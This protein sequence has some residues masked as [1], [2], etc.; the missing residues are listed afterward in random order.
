MKKSLFAS[1]LLALFSSQV[2]AN[3]NLTELEEELDIM[4]NILRTSLQQDKQKAGLRVGQM[5][6]TYLDGQGVVFDM[7]TSGGQHWP[8]VLSEK[9]RTLFI[10]PLE[11]LSVAFGEDFSFH[12]DSDDFNDVVEQAQEAAERARDKIHRLRDRQRDYSWEIRELERE[13]RDLQFAKRN[14]DKEQAAEITAELNAA[15]KRLQELQRQQNQMEQD[16]EQLQA[17][18]RKLAEEQK[19]AQRKLQGRFLSDFEAAL[20]KTLCRYGSGL[21]ALPA[22]EKIS[23]VLKRF[24]T[25]KDGK[26]RKDRIY[27]FDNSNVQACVRDK[28]TQEQLLAKTKVYSF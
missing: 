5:N 17:E 8:L 18:Q 24:T 19:Q 1:V 20:G 4:R 21:R 26:T 23:F 6:Y 11:N 14:A 22:Q 28:L 12:F 7:T 27:V 3:I 16:A 9:G 15:E 13:K 25:G 2:V 10:E